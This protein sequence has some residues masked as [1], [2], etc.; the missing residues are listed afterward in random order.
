MRRCLRAREGSRRPG[1]SS[2]VDLVDLV[3]LRTVFRGAGG[4]AAASTSRAAARRAFLLGTATSGVDR[5][6]GS[7]VPNGRVRGIAQSPGEGDL[8]GLYRAR[9]GARVVVES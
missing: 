7:A 8:L 5:R 4:V 2:F 3:D 1:G 6:V 9:S